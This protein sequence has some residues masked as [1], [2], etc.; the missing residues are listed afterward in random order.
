ML[1]LRNDRIVPK[2]IFRLAFSFVFVAVLIITM[3]FSTIELVESTNMTFLEVFVLRSRIYNAIILAGMDFLHL[4]T[5]WIDYLFYLI[6][7]LM[8]CVALG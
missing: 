7:G 3:V 8:D 2:H 6:N 1:Q 5:Q 4:Q